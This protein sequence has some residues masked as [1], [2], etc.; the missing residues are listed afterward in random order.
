MRPLLVT[1]GSGKYIRAQ[2]DCADLLRAYLLRHGI[3][4]SSPVP[5]EGVTSLIRLGASADAG[6]VQGILDGWK[7]PC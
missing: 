2:A 3:P 4:C 5:S 7:W 6:F 1:T